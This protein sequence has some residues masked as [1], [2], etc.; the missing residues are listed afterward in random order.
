MGLTRYEVEGGGGS[1]MVVRSQAVWSKLPPVSS[2]SSFGFG[3]T[4]TLLRNW[5]SLS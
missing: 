3:C 2:G 1:I 4:G 5:L